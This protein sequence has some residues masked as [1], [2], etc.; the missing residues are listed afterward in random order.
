MAKY[1]KSPEYVLA[2]RELREYDVDD[3]VALLGITTSDIISKFPHKVRSYLKTQE[4]P[5]LR[6]NYSEEPNDDDE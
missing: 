4:I 1:R 5:E 2:A 6:Y 3:L